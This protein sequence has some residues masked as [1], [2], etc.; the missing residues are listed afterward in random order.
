ME[1]N[2]FTKNK[3]KILIIK[4]LVFIFPL[5]LVSGPLVPD[6]IIS[7]SSLLFIVFF[8]NEILFSLKNN[9]FIKIFFLFF[10]YLFIS[11]FFSE[12]LSISLKSSFTYLRFVIF[13]CLVC[14]LHKN[15]PE[16]IYI[17][18]LGLLF[19]FV[20]LSLDA[21]LQYFTGKNFFGFEPQQ[22]PLRISG[23]F[24]DEL[25]LG[26]YLSRLYPLLIGLF[27][28]FFYKKKFFYL[29]IIILTILVSFT[30]F[31]SAERTSIVLHFISLTL[32]TLFL[33][34]PKKYKLFIFFSIICSS[35]IVVSNNIH[36]KQRVINETLLNSDNAKYIFSKVHHAHYLTSI[37][38]FID[39]PI[40]G[41][42]VKTFRYLCDLDK[43]KVD[44]F[45]KPFKYWQ[46]S[47]S[48]HPHNIYIQ[49]LSET[50][51]FGFMF[52]FFFFI[53][54][55]GNLFKNLP[56]KGVEL[57]CRRAIYVCLF[58]NFFPFAPSGNFFNN[59][60]S[61]MYILPLAFMLLKLKNNN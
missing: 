10:L 57:Y 61:M 34:I 29:N 27:F 53:T 46:F 51:I 7:I 48:T 59:Y 42:G 52:L 22:T 5:T 45:K 18:F 55:V 2:Y 26:S 25:V 17:F 40:I 20:I 15:Y 19:T 28:L 23:M 14:Y 9:L 58:I 49:L 24:K 35:I 8:Y 33:N 54:I 13:V 38:I 12:V 1:I 31:I 3:T 44:R 4:F 50:G 32:L 56:E 11:S 16:I 39:K 36:I 60:V 41:S 43:Y 6:L 37:N 21:N 30:I 47:C